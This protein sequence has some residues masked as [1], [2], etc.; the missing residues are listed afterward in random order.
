MG[1][2]SA[3]HSCFMQGS[4]RQPTYP[5]SLT[6]GDRVQS[7]ILIKQGYGASRWQRF[8]TGEESAD[9][10]KKNSTVVRVED[11]IAAIT[12]TWTQ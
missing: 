10:S 3:G 12:M 9:L 11:A 5:D 6:F 2:P 4:F 8:N 1:F 7:T